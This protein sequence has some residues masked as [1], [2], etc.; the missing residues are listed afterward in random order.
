MTNAAD[1]TT[2]ELP[3]ELKPSDGR[4]WRP[5]GS[6]YWQASTPAGAIYSRSLWDQALGMPGKKT[7]ETWTLRR[8]DGPFGHRLVIISRLIRPDATGSLTWS[9]GE[10]RV[11]CGSI[12]GNPPTLKARAGTPAAIA[13]TTE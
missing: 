12:S 5:A 4:F 10:N 6:L 2:L 9:F 3:S 7:G 11:S 1:P 8:A 13:S